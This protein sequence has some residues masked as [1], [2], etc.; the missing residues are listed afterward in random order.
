MPTLTPRTWWNKFCAGEFIYEVVIA[1]GTATLGTLTAL[2]HF[3]KSPPDNVTGW[4]ALAAVIVVFGTL[5]LR[6]FQRRRKAQNESEPHAL[7]CVLFT[8]HAILLGWSKNAA[9]ASLR[10]CVFVPIRGSETV[11]QITDYVGA[12]GDPRHGRGQEIPTSKGIVGLAIRSGEA[13]Y[14]H[15]A[16]GV[17]LT[18]YLIET[19]GYTRAEALN[20]REDRKSWA[21]IPVGVP[22][23]VEAVL[24]LDCDQARFF[25][26][27]QIKKI[28]ESATIGVA[29]YLQPI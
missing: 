2:T 25:E 26:R 12:N 17:P 23:R 9:N 13:K 5:L 16:P 8:L 21:A 19:Y 24:F 11:Q 29:R 6:A 15:L 22:G 3:R 4:G 28:L 7:D 20:R 1:V 14:D 10:I 27:E 18:D